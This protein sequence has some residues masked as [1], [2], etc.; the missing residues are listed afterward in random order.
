MESLRQVG[1]GLLL[2]IISIIIILSGFSLAMVEAG[3]API[4]ASTPPTA[5]P[6]VSIL[7]TGFPTLPLPSTNTPLAISTAT[8]TA[9]SI[10]STT[11]TPTST[12]LST[13]PATLAICPPPY[14][15]RPIVVQAD[16]TLASLA[17]QYRTT[18]ELLRTKNCLLN[19]QL[20]TGSILYVPPVPT[21]TSFACGS[22]ANWGYYRVSAGDTLYH[23]GVLYRVSVSQLMQAN[24][25]YTSSISA[26]QLLRVPNVATSTPAFTTPVPTLTE[27]PSATPLPTDTPSDTPLPATPTETAIP[28]ASDTQTPTETATLT[29]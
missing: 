6:T 23:I 2:G 26:G 11:P 22:P 13:L 15:W 28:T 25:L 14:G 10:S 20:V 24:C 7:V 17:L 1:A 21:S 19:D 9:T 5:S 12:Y 4:A 16:Q 18:A 27:I 29:S 3:L 8:P